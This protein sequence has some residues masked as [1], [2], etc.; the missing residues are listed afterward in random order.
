M[1]KVKSTMHERPEQAKHAVITAG[2]GRGFIVKIRRP[3]RVISG[4]NQYKVVDILRYVITAAHCLPFFPP[5]H[6]T[7][8]LNERTYKAVLGPLGADP[9]VWAEC[10]FVDPVADIA[11]LGP[12]DNQ[13][14]WA[15]CEAYEALVDAATPLPLA[16]AAASSPAWLLSREGQWFRCQVEN[17]GAGW[18]I[19][20]AAQPISGGMSGS[21][22]LSD[23]GRAIGLVS[24][25]SGTGAHDTDTEGGPNPRLA[26]NLPRWLAPTPIPLK[27]RRYDPF[28]T[29]IETELVDGRLAIRSKSET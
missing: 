28:E 17:N 27:L 8:Y 12:P 22:I 19:K 2:D 13:A 9:A 29:E 7:S 5:C 3:R 16:D 6:P 23:E 24:I 25:S 26:C 20:D 15:Q 11:V 18:W 10:V 4:P 14:L 1:A 21:P